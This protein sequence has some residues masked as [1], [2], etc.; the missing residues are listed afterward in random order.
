[1]RYGIRNRSLELGWAEALTAAAE[2]GF[3]GVELVAMPLHVRRWLTP[4]GRD[5][6]LAWSEA[7]GCAIASLGVAPWRRYS[8]ALPEVD[9]GVGVRAVCDCVRAAHGLGA[10]AVL[11]PIFDVA[12]GDVDVAAEAR[13][14]EGFRRCAPL[15]EELDVAI[16]LETTFSIE[17]LER[18]VDRV[19]SGRF[20]VYEDVGNSLRF[21]RDPAEAI[22]R[23]GRRIAM[24]HVKEEGADALGAGRIDWPACVA[25]MRDVGY[26]GWLVLETRP[27]EDPRRA[28]ADNL[29]FLRELTGAPRAVAPSRPAGAR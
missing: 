23:L 16:A 28:A 27:T 12:R 22:R 3:D 20:G 24:M 26:E 18:I 1:V 8:F 14:I 6:A 11:L 15:A 5:E 7:A 29:A 25:A 21:G 17:Q 4:E 10:G 13:L 9:M 2:L 19:G